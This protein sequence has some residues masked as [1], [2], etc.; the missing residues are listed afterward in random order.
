VTLL[1]FQGHVFKGEGHSETVYGKISTGDMFS[2]LSVSGMH[3]HVLLKLL[4]INHYQSSWPCWHFKVMYSKVKVTDNIFWFAVD[5][6]LVLFVFQRGRYFLLNLFCFIS[7][8]SQHCKKC[9]VVVEQCLW[10]AAVC[11]KIS[12]KTHLWASFFA[13]AA[14]CNISITVKLIILAV[15]SIKLFWCLWFLHFCFPNYY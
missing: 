6:H 1:T 5:N 14:K 10:C 13:F 7:I 3:G 2:P 8:M 12:W 11:C 4:T 9:V 15:R